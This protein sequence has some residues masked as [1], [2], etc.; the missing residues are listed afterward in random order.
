MLNYNRYGGGTIV[1]YLWFHK[2]MKFSTYDSDNDY[3]KNGGSCSEYYG[4]AGFWYNDCAVK[5]F[6]LYYNFLDNT[7][8]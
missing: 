5:Q 2:D 3:R 1:D 6:F 7:F 8:N 4:G